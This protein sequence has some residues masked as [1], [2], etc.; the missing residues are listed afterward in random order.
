M[1]KFDAVIVSIWIG[2]SMINI[3][4]LVM[5]IWKEEAKVYSIDS[6]I[7]FIQLNPNLFIKLLVI[8]GNCSWIS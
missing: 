2:I 7:L 6:Q 3:I 1:H 5:C 8:I 4:D